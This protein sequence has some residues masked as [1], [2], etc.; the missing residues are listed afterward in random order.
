MK[1]YAEA[2]RKVSELVHTKPLLWVMT[3]IAQQERLLTDDLGEDRPDIHE[4]C[5]L[6]KPLLRCLRDAE[7]F[8]LTPNEQVEIIRWLYFNIDRMKKWT[9]ET[10]ET[11]LNDLLD[12]DDTHRL[13]KA[14]YYDRICWFNKDAADLLVDLIHISGYYLKVFDPSGNPAEQIED[15]L[16]FEKA[17]AILKER[18][19]GAEYQYD[20]LI[21]EEE[22]DEEAEE[23][24]DE[25]SPSD[26]DL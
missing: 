6:V 9:A 16:L 22:E 4:K 25:A 10:L 21:M 7:L 11:D 17:A 14:N 24:E 1:Q 8:E 15:T 2:A 23:T 19:E 12:Q 18:I 13:L 5:H 20:R 3:L 26:E